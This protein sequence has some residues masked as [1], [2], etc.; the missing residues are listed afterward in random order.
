MSKHQFPTAL[1]SNG[2]YLLGYARKT[3]NLVD[4]RATLYAFGTFGGGAINWQWSPDGGTTKLPMN[5][6][7]GNPIVSLVNDSFNSQL[8]SGSHN[9][10]QV[11]IY[12]AL[13]SSSNP[14][15]TV[16]YFDN[17]Y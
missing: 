17:N 13:V 2:T 10:D 12:A 7:S 9:N 4:W 11:L 8:C 15:L 6:L 14:N 3:R 16:G 5:D 1:T